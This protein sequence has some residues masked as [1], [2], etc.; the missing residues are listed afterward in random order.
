MGSHSPE[1]YSM[2]P[3]EAHPAPHR[4][5]EHNSSK[6]RFLSKTNPPQR[7]DSPAEQAPATGHRERNEASPGSHSSYPQCVQYKALERMYNP[8]I[9][10]KWC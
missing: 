7:H 9:R 10:Y 6:G 5:R 2:T 1:P 8:E 4:E 3:D